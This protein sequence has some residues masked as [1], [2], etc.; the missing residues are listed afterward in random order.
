MTKLKSAM[1]E[2][3][4]KLLKTCQNLKETSINSEHLKGY[5][6]ALESVAKDIGAQML[7]TEREYM[8]NAIEAALEVASESATIEVIQ[9]NE[10]TTDIVG[11][12]KQSITSLINHPNLKV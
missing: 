2:L 11:V 4:D 3:R 8:K 6:E 5:C 7:A 1:T 9:N 12:S 10:G